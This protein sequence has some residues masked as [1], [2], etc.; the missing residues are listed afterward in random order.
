MSKVAQIPLMPSGN[1][2]V[3]TSLKVSKP[4]KSDLLIDKS[5]KDDEPQIKVN[6]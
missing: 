2:L 4:V 6:H 1:R 3:L 5:I